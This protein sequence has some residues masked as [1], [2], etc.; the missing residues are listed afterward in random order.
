MCF[1]CVPRSLEEL[2]VFLKEKGVEILGVSHPNLDYSSYVDRLSFKMFDFDPEY[3]VDKNAKDVIEML[4]CHH[5]NYL[6]DGRGV[7]FHELLSSD[8]DRFTAFTKRF[9][10]PL[11]FK[12][13]YKGERARAGG[14]GAAA[15]R[16]VRRNMVN[17]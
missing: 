5:L 15:Y 4:D 8:T 11:L 6:L 3:V 7:A 2:N 10:L 12:V 17:G 14:G 9:T 1:R 13:K 16:Y